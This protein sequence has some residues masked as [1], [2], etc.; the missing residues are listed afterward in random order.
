M[1]IAKYVY[2]IFLLVVAFLVSVIDPSW[3]GTVLCWFLVMIGILSCFIRKY[4]KSF[5]IRSWINRYF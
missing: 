1:S 5:W 4:A 3:K 2:G